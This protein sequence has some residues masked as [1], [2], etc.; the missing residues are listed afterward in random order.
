MIRFDVQIVDE[1]DNG[2]NSVSK[3]G[4][5]FATSAKD[6]TKKKEKNGEEKKRKSEI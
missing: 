2:D 5:S 3:E 6:K 1:Q 4:S